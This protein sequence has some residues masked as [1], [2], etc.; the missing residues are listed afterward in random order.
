MP[1]DKDIPQSAIQSE[2]KNESYATCIQLDAELHDK[3]TDLNLSNQASNSQYNSCPSTS[4]IVVSCSTKSEP[5]YKLGIQFD[6][7]SKKL[8]SFLERVE[9]LAHARRITKSFLFLNP[10]VTYLLEKLRFGYDK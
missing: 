3:V 8:L 7:E 6:G 5:V 2:F 10:Q 9:E 1:I 4:N